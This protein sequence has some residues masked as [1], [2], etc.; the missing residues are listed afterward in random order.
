M[1]SFMKLCSLAWQN[2]YVF[3]SCRDL[4]GLQ[5]GEWSLKVSPTQDHVHF[6]KLKTLL[7]PKG[8]M[9]IVGFQ[10]AARLFGA[11]GT[12]KDSFWDR[13][14]A[15][16][17]KEPVSPW[18]TCWVWGSS[19]LTG[20]WFEVGVRLVRLRPPELTLLPRQKEI[21][22]E[23]K[24]NQPRWMKP[25]ERDLGQNFPR[26]L[27]QNFPR[28][29]MPPTQV[30]K[31]FLLQTHCQIHSLNTQPF[32]FFSASWVIVRNT[33]T[34]E[35][36]SGPWPPVHGPQTS[37]EEPWSAAPP[38]RYPASAGLRIFTACSGSPPKLW[39]PSTVSWEPRE[40]HLLL[41]FFICV[42]IQ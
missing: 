42:L 31:R 26:I 16:G 24:K 33:L 17:E 4:I 19:T 20:G 21:H 5:A 12:L 34:W 14:P 3:F 9:S 22:C 1:N 36:K 10:M 7:N 39:M 40:F 30:K 23:E 13:K 15:L 35:W 38:A 37:G 8:W 28:I 41:L 27:G 18:C 29:L 25:G 11:V 2:V 32:L 6:H